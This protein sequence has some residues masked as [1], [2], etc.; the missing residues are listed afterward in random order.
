MQ[1]LWAN[2]TRRTSFALHALRTLRANGTSGTSFALHALWTLRANGTRRTGFALH[3]LWTLRANGTR[4]PRITLNTLRALWTG[5]SSRARITLRSRISI[6]RIRSHGC[7]RHRLAWYQRLAVDGDLQPALLTCERAGETQADGE[8]AIGDGKLRFKD[9]RPDLVAAGFGIKQ[10]KA[11]VVLA[12]GRLTI[13]REVAL[14]GEVRQLRDL[15]R[16]NTGHANQGSQQKRDE[17]LHGWQSSN[18]LRK[19]VSVVQGLPQKPALT[20]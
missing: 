17:C 10:R 6:Q 20:R 8:Q 1:T 14:I 15:R 11:E 2:R 12:R 3:T 19:R 13:L 9:R 7:G 16:G 5:D 18:A 4:R